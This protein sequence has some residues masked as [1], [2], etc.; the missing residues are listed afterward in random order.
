MYQSGHFRTQIFEEL[1]AV[2]ECLEEETG[3]MLSDW[4]QLHES[5]LQQGSG[6]ISVPAGVCKD[7]VLPSGQ[8]LCTTRSFERSASGEIERFV[9]LRS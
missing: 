5:C 4:T 1:L 7:R 9:L 3:N 6:M 2:V 8:F